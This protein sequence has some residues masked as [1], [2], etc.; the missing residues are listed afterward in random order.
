MKTRLLIAYIFAHLVSFSQGDTLCENKET[1]CDTNV[2][3]SKLKDDTN[4]VSK[5]RKYVYG[6]ATYY[7]G[8]FIG[9]KTTNGEIFTS[10]DL[11]CAHMYYKFGT[12]LRVT[13]IKNGKSVI[14]RVN[15]RGGFDKYGV[16]VDLSRAAFKRIANVKDGKVIVKIEK[17]GKT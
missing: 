4:F 9:R 1:L 17:L 3:Q 14:V 2:D 8:K 16:A 13:N 11:T 5:A 6:K 15:D 10:N 12:M 7:A